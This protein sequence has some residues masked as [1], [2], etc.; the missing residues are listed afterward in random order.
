[1]SPPKKKQNEPSK[2]TPRSV[3]AKSKRIVHNRVEEPTKIFEFLS[4]TRTRS[5]H[6]IA[7]CPIF[8]LND[9]CLLEV[10]SYL[11]DVVLCA[12]KD[13][14]RRF[15]ALPDSVVQKRFQKMSE[16]K[17]TL[18]RDNQKEF[19]LTLQHFG[20]FIETPMIIETE[21][22]V[23]VKGMWSHLKHCTALKALEL[24]SMNIEGIPCLNYRLKKIF[25]NLH[26]LKL[27]RCTGKDL[28]FAR[29]INACEN[30]RRLHVFCV[31]DGATDSLI[32]HIARESSCIEDLYFG[33]FP[34]NSETFS[35][36]VTKIRNLKKLHLF[37]LYCQNHRVA[38]AIE[39]LAAENRIAQIHL[40]NVRADEELGR[41]FNTFTNLRFSTVEVSTDSEVTDALKQSFVN[42]TWD[43]SQN[44]FCKLIL[45][46]D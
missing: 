18:N 11:S 44:H 21:P 31:Q 22:N 27:I 43:A 2:A 41:A 17:Y 45:Y 37:V 40:I 24:H 9:D 8:I 20:K 26:D 23:E 25:R 19:A 28:D 12:V 34:S 38:S 1:M 5:Q 36:N 15:N 10:F 6:A 7:N 33:S 14:C 42:F 46:G 30:L 32:S 4:P 35:E 13:T 39:A 3:A 29:I 16:F